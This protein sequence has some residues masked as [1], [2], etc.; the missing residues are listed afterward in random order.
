MSNSVLVVISALVAFRDDLNF[1]F[2]IAIAALSGEINRYAFQN[3]LE[4]DG[5]P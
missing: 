5:A 1:T 2:S 4:Y 3:E